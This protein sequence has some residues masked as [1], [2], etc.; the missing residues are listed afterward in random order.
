MVPVSGLP[1]PTTME[2]KIPIPKCDSKQQTELIVPLL[3]PAKCRTRVVSMSENLK[4]GKL[5]ALCRY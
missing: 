5:T 4:E 1:D 2:L 3:E